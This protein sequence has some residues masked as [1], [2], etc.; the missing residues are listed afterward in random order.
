MQ[1]QLNVTATPFNFLEKDYE[2]IKKLKALSHPSAFS[3]ID[4]IKYHKHI[5]SFI[6]KP[7][8]NSS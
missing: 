2:N 3:F 7:L 4:S 8:N 6:F 1:T 5:E